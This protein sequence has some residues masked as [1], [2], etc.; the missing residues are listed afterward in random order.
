M[1][2]IILIGCPG[3]GKS[4]LS[5]K[6]SQIL[7]YPILHLDKIYHIDNTKNIGR[8]E[9]VRKIKEFVLIND[10]WIID[11]NYLGTIDLRIDLCDTIVLLNIDKDICIKNV[12]KR[13]EIGNTA[14]AE[15]FDCSKIDDEFIRFIKE[16]KEKHY[17]SIY[18]KCVN[19]TRKFIILS[20]YIEINDFLKSIEKRQKAV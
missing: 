14:M 17:P 10:K 13:V 2:K 20:D 15:K 12:Y 18:D 8:E 4:T 16:F 5:V 11:G 19:S 6:L 9:I 1:N 7:N 3:S